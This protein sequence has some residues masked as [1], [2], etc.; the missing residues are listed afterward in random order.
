MSEVLAAALDDVVAQEIAGWQA[1][2]S[3]VV[4][5]SVD[6]PVASAG[7]LDLVQQWA[8]V[9]KIVAALAVL[10]V[11]EE[12]LLDLD[13]AAGPPGSTVRHLLGHASGLAFDSARVVSKPG[14]RRV[15]SNVGIDLAVEVA[16]SRSGVR[17]ATQLVQERVLGPLG[18]RNTSLDGPPSSGARGPVRD[19]ALLG[20]ELLVPRALA[21]AVVAAAVAPSFVGLAGL[22]PGFGRQDPNDWGLGIE[23]RGHKTPHWMAPEAPPDCFGHFGQSGCFLWVDRSLGLAAVAATGTTFGPWAAVAWPSSSTRWRQAWR[24]GLPLSGDRS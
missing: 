13:D 1:A 17:D 3:A 2:A 22:L 6:G 7:P 4:L 20:Q 14:S 5:V 10:D 15:Y 16:V 18:M 11:V 23:R 9:T 24:T 21:P 19:L 12:G 8:S